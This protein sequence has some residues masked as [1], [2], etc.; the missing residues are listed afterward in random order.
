MGF[1]DFVAPDPDSFRQ[2]LL[3]LVPPEVSFGKFSLSAEQLIDLAYATPAGAAGLAARLFYQAGSVQGSSLAAGQ[4]LVQAQLDNL[5]RGGLYPLAPATAGTDLTE[6][7]SMAQIVVANTYECT[8]RA[9]S[10]GRAVDNVIHFVGTGSGQEQACAVALQTAWKGAGKPFS[11]FDN[12]VSLVSFQA[13][14]LTSVSGGIWTIPDTTAG[15]MTAASLATR[16][17]CAL[18]QYNGQTRNRSSRGRTY[19]GPAYEG[20][21]QIDGATL[22]TSFAGT[23]LTTWNGLRT[24]MLAAGFTQAVV[25]RKLQVAYPITSVRI[26]TTVATQRRRLRA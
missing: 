21:I 5:A 23:L 25:S 24:A 20:W 11:Y 14:D 2:V 26:S 12:K 18:I 4:S 6:G 16:A 10:G 8:I 7:L 1:W 19:F 13:V 9:V 17:A 15:S 3:P 22:D